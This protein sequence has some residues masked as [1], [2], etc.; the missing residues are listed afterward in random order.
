M[1]RSFYHFI[2]ATKEGTNHTKTV[3]ITKVSPYKTGF[4][5]TMSSSERFKFVP[6]PDFIL[7]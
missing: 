5:V 3:Y 2:I 4:N 6:L 7:S 1:Y